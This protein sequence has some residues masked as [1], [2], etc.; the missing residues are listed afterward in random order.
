MENKEK[1]ELLEFKK[2]MDVICQKLRVLERQ[3]E[4]SYL[5]FEEQPFLSAIP[6]CKH[7]LCIIIEL[8]NHYSLALKE[9][10]DLSFHLLSKLNQK[11]AEKTKNK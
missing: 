1:H 3:I 5:F 4:V 7:L 11:V 9:I 2:E 10:R 6:D 8:F